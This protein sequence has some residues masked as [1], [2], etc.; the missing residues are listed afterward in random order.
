[1]GENGLLFDR[2][3]ALVNA[4]GNV[5]TL[6]DCPQLAK[7]ACSIDI[8]S[9]KQLLISYYAYISRYLHTYPTEAQAFLL[10]CLTV[11]SQTSSASHTLLA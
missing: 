7:I 2:E 4:A 8:D 5:M 6:K 1:M 10:S 3:W 11:Q 9:G